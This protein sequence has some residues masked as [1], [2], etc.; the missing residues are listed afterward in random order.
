MIIARIGLLDPASIFVR[1]GFKRSLKCDDC[2]PLPLLSGA[3]AC[4]R[5][6]WNR[7]DRVTAAGGV[8]PEVSSVVGGVA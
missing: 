5:A 7:S 6:I 1:I 3:T 8:Q 2:P 4:S